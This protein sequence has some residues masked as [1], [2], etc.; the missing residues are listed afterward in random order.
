MVKQVLVSYIGVTRLL[1]EQV[2]QV[3]ELLRS[4]SNFQTKL[5]VIAIMW[6]S[7]VV[8]NDVNTDVHL[9]RYLSIINIIIIIIVSH[10]AVDIWS[11]GVILLSLPAIGNEVM[12]VTGLLY[13]PYSLAAAIHSRDPMR[14]MT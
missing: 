8:D 3:S 12:I 13:P 6:S 1:Q 9:Y 2:L 14:A 5:Q 10:T 4:Y 11:A 7:S